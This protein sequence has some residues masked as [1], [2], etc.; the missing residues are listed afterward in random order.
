M[1]MLTILLKAPPPQPIY[2]HAFGLRAGSGTMEIIPHI[3]KPITIKAEPTELQTPGTIT[4]ITSPIEMYDGT[5]LPAGIPLSWWASPQAIT[6]G[7]ADHETTER[8]SIYTWRSNTITDA[9]IAEI[10]NP[11]GFENVHFSIS[12]GSDLTTLDTSSNKIVI[13]PPLEAPI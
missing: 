7:S 13:A 9:Q 10:G 5:P 3:L 2:L 11:P 1:A 8:R 12:F 4:A 6:E